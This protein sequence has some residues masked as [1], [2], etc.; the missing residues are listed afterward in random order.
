MPPGNVAAIDTSTSFIGGPS[1]PVSVI[2]AQI[3]G[4]QQLTGGFYGLRTF[5]IELLASL[6]Y[7]CFFSLQHHCCH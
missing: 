4:S 5:G 3:P 7:I 2:Y 6:L 1:A